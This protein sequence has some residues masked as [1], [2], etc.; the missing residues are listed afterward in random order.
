MDM[1]PKTKRNERMDI[2]FIVDNPQFN[3]RTKHKSKSWRQ[4]TNSKTGDE[5]PSTKQLLKIQKTKLKAISNP[6]AINPKRKITYCNIKFEILYFI[7]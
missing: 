2:Q 7:Y 4:N 5:V 3:R 6:I 1:K